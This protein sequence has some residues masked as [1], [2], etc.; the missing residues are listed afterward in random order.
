MHWHHQKILLLW[1][2]CS[3]SY[4]LPSSI[5]SEVSQRLLD[6][7]QFCCTEFACLPRPSKDI[8][9]SKATELRCF[10]LYLGP[11]VLKNVLDRER[12]EH[13]LVLHVAIRILASP[14][15][16]TAYSTYAKELLCFFYVLSK[17]CTAVERCHTTFTG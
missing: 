5:V 15:M 10:L 9:F 8:V 11:V 12:Y 17:L 6:L 1:I 2:K 16:C 4:R 7:K 3:K 14:R 13:F